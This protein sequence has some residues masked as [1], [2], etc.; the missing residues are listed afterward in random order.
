MQPSTGG[1]LAFLDPQSIILVDLLQKETTILDAYCIN[2]NPKLR[3][4]I[5]ARSSS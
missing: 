2:L 5:L 1:I 4:R 3:A